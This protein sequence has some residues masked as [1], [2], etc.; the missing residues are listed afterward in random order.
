M[1]VL[2]VQLCRLGSTES[3]KFNSEE[4][5]GGGV[6]LFEDTELKKPEDFIF[7]GLKA[8]MSP[9]EP[10]PSTLTDFFL[11]LYLCL[12]VRAFPAA[13]DCRVQQ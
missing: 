8:S 10:T 1:E 9:N 11:C 2:R 4:T 5:V 13:Q 12:S 3:F 6:K 7:S